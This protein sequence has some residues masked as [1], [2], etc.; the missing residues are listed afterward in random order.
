M[1]RKMVWVGCVGADDGGGGGGEEVRRDGG[2]VGMTVFQY[3]W[4]LSSTGDR[5][6]MVV[7]LLAVAMRMKTE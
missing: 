2:G 7:E 5:H 6:Y 3:L 1:V 4:R